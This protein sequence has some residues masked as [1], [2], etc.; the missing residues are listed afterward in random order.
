M[1]TKME[2]YEQTIKPLM[3]KVIEAC[4]ANN[5]ALVFG[6]EVSAEGHE[7]SPEVMALVSGLQNSKPQTPQPLLVASQVLDGHFEVMG[8]I[9]VVKAPTAERL[10]FG[11]DTYE[12][13]FKEDL[14]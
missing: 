13:I 3:N 12:K 8:P 5:I 14:A 11:G 10:R 1:P 2:I 6:I 4:G 7:D 9:A